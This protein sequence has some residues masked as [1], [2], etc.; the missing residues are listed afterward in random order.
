M[1][2]QLHGKLS[3]VP[4]GIILSNRLQCSKEP[5]RVM[6]DL[7]AAF[8]PE[9]PCPLLCSRVLQGICLVIEVQGIGRQPLSLLARPTPHLVWRPFL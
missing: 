4:V 8:A 3:V 2:M 7:C 1:T 9:Q 6:T 5:S